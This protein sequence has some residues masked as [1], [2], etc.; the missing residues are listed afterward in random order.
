MKRYERRLPHWD[1]IGQP[2]FVTFRLHGTLP[3]GRI[4]EPKSLSDSGQAFVMMDRILDRATI[5]PT[6]LRIPQIADLLVSALQDG[7]TRNY[8][9]HNPVKAGL[10]A[11]AEEFRWSSAYKSAG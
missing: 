5:G 3:S 4:F 6:Y 9:E 2:L 8:I 7:A 11:A 10:T 1:Q